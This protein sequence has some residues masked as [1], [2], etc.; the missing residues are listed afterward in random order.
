MTLFVPAS[1][2][3]C[4][5]A[6]RIL[7]LVKE[8]LPNGRQ[9]NGEWRVGSVYGEPGSSLAVQLVGPR[10]GL[11]FDYATGEGGDALALVRAVLD[12]DMRAALAWS[13]RWLGIEPGS[14]D[15]PQRP[16]PAPEPKQDPDSWRYPWQ[17][18]LPIAGTLAGTY[19]AGRGRRF[20]DL[21]GRVL[22][23][24][25]QRARKS[26][27]GEFEC[28]PALLCALSDARSGEQCGIINIYL[29]ADGSDRLRDKKGK[30]V[31]G[32][33]AGAVVMLST[34]DEPT[35]GL[36]LCEGVETGVA[37][38]QDEMRPVWACGA[39][40]TLRKFPVLGGIETLT[41]GADA[42]KPGIGAAEELARHWRAA[43]RQV[44]IITPTAGDWA[45]PR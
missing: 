8:L 39:A 33:A 37:L 40:G 18:A 26:P 15:I 30:T 25:A 10:A 17:A 12:G 5:L 41:I 42:D 4:A 13:C 43:G 23:F 29:R 32:R 9:V 1:D 6:K 7:Q 2:S 45:D 28:H 22:R 34:F 44:L 27:E 38:F 24:A 35:T 31:T 36:V 14:T 20:D 3:S 19:L 11:W 16:P 21:T